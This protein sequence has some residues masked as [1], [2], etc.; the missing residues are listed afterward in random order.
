[1]LLPAIKDFRNSPIVIES[2]PLEPGSSYDTLIPEPHD[3]WILLVRSYLPQTGAPLW[4]KSA[5]EAAG[6][7]KVDSIVDEYDLYLR[8]LMAGSRFLYCPHVG[9]VYRK[10]SDTTLSQ[11][12]RPEVARQRAQIIDRAEKILTARGELTDARRRAV[13]RARYKMAWCA[14]YGWF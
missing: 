2:W 12:D 11:R 9:A 4:G 14:Q 6:G 10:W 8:L 3:P 5:V 7:W 1:M 13:D